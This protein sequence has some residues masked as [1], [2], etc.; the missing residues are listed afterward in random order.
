M[1]K[2]TKKWKCG[3]SWYIVIFLPYLGQNYTLID[4]WICK[5]SMKF[6]FK[7]AG[8]NCGIGDRLT[9]CCCRK[10]HKVWNTGILAAHSS[11]ILKLYDLEGS[12][13]LC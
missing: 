11:Q 2:P 7:T 10:K 8:K 1:L 6:F 9:S 12:M 3:C 13:G 5:Y 4:I